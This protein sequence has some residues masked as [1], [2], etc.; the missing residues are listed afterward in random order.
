MVFRSLI[1]NFEIG[2]K[3]KEIKYFQN[4]ILHHKKTSLPADVVAFSCIH[5]SNGG[6]HL[7]DAH[8]W[9][10]IIC[11]TIKSEYDFSNSGH[12]EYF[13]GSVNSDLYN[14]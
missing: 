1:E 5:I 4:E 9:K 11:N 10:W 13:W 12:F 14:S 7:S 8:Q 6:Y 2:L 3:T